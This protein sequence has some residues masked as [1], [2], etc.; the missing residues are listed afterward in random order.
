MDD[1]F[2]QKYHDLEW[3]HWWF[4]ARRATIRMLIRGLGL[5]PQQRLL[6]I[7]CSGGPSLE[8]LA[9]EGFGDVHGIDISDFISAFFAASASASSFS[10]FA[11]DSL[12]EKDF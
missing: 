7:G 6:E 4:R 5:S 11:S 1:A 12:K 2:E 10:S 3:D 9:K 8:M